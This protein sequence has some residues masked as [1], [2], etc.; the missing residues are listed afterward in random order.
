LT[1]T[2]HQERVNLLLP[3]NVT[4]TTAYNREYS[5]KEVRLAVKNYH[6]LPKMSDIYLDLSGVYPFLS[7][8]W[9]DVFDLYSKGYQL[10]AIAAYW[11][12]LFSGRARGR[13]YG[14]KIVARLIDRLKF[15]LNAAVV[16]IDGAALANAEQIVRVP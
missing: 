5:Q 10:D 6:D 12:N 14:T 4:G 1:A 11:S 16:P 9:K 2:S 8:E 3:R 15:Y 7:R 13:N